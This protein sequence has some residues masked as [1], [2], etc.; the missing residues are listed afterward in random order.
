MS[1]RTSFG[2]APFSDE[3]HTF[4]VSADLLGAHVQPE[5]FF[6]LLLERFKVGSIL[7]GYVFVAEVKAVHA[8]AQEDA[9]L[10][11]EFIKKFVLVSGFDCDLEFEQHQLFRFISKTNNKGYRKFTIDVLEIIF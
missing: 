5:E 9:H 10:K 2:L 4:Q 3:K 8:L 6:Q 11:L 1:S 7:F